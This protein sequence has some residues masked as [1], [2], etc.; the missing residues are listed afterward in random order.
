VI[1]SAQPDMGPEE[2]AAVLAVLD[3]GHLASGAV[4]KKLE[5]EF[6]RRVAGT[7]EAVAVSSGT[8]ALH[9]ALLAHGVGPGDE[10]ITTALSF[11]ATANM[12]L[13]AGARPVF[14]DVRED[15]NIDASQIEAA[16]TPQTKAILPVH[17]YGRLC[18]IE[19]IERIAGAH[20]LA[21]IED[22]AQ[23]HGAETCGGRAGGFGTG[24]FSFYATKNIT[25]G[26]G[27]MLTTNDSALA[28]KMR[29]LRSHGEI[30]RY[31]SVELGFNYRM[32][33]V[34]SA[35]ALVQLG[36][37]P[38]YNHRRRQNAAYLSR[39]LEGVITP[40]EPEDEAAHVWHQYVILVPQGRDDLLRWLR[41]RDIEAG[42]YYPTP[43]PFQ[44]LYRDLGFG[45]DFPVA[46]RLAREVLSLP[47][48]SGLSER[49]L[50]AIVEGVNSWTR[51][52]G[53]AEAGTNA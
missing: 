5:E 27:G 47:V 23:A 45:G 34:A 17:L 14:V 49:D 28:D 46:A 32:T 3:S 51:V 19:T 21:L 37:L 38:E 42:V 2:R 9:V 39:R 6:A 26:E 48:H 12:V 16:I 4:T 36:K 22:A 13:A 29:R 40:P 7:T 52:R 31:S 30:E 8:A 50:E 15:G 24:C 53:P 35:I 18:N 20:G 41:D 11:Q 43:I 10:V 25:A 33:D 44:P 1:R